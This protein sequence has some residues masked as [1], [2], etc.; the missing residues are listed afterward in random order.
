M[1]ESSKNVILGVLGGEIHASQILQK[2]D[3]LKR[4]WKS[5]HNDALES[6]VSLPKSEISAVL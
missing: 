6:A 1:E 3:I 5:Q 4:F 2:C